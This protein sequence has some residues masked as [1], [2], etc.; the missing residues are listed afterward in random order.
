MPGLLGVSP[1]A[2]AMIAER[3]L[4]GSLA[5]PFPFPFPSRAA[6]PSLFLLL[7]TPFS[8]IRTVKSSYHIADMAPGSA[9]KSQ[10]DS[11][12]P[13]GGHK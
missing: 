13:E 7:L 10:G 5:L 2:W 1:R 6:F 3:D 4:H 8:F 12:E 9:R 11:M